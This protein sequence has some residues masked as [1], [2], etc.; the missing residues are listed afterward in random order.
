MARVLVV[1]DEPF[2]REELQ[3]SLELEDFDVTTACDVPHALEES[4]KSSF[5]VVVTDLKMPKMGGLELIRELKNRAYQGIVIVVSGHGAES[6]REEAMAHGAAACFAK[7]VDTD[8]LIEA[9]NARI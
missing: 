9:I 4:A 6:S 5:D 3:E 7:P 8:E 2:L 1:D